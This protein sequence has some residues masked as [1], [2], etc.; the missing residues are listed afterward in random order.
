MGSRSAGLLH[1]GLWSWVKALGLEFYEPVRRF[2]EDS[3]CRELAP[4]HGNFVALVKPGTDVA[5]LV[6]LV[7]KIFSLRHLESLPRK[8]FGSSGKEADAIHAMPLGF[9]HQ[10][11]H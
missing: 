9:G 5:I 10:R 4:H 2:R 3:E 1:S 6:D 7:G 11:L 8:K